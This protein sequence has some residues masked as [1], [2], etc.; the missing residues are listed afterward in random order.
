MAEIISSGSKCWTE[1]LSIWTQSPSLPTPSLKDIIVITVA[2]VTTTAVQKQI[3]CVGVGVVF[4]QGD[5][6][7]SSAPPVAKH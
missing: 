3:C 2:M 5:H 1:H 7:D 4:G 6:S